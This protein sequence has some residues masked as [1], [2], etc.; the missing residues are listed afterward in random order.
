M[1][2]CVCV[3]VCLCMCVRA[4]VYMHVCVCVCMWVCACERVFVRANMSR[5]CVCSCVCACVCVCVRVCVCVCACHVCFCV[6][7]CVRV[8]VCVC[9]CVCVRACVF[10]FP[11]P[12]FPSLLPNLHRL[13]LLP[14]R[15]V[16]GGEVFRSHLCHIIRCLTSATASLQRRRRFVEACLGLEHFGCTHARDLN[17][18]ERMHMPRSIILS[19]THQ[20]PNPLPAVSSK[21][22]G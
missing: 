10:L 1:R 6:S 9:V 22:P 3:P 5:V 20:A 18:Y 8:S 13:P 16:G 4:R 12:P 2:A 19:R 11:M 17:I 21:I 7:V 15:F 14:G